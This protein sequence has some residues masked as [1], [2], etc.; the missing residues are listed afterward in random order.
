[1]EFPIRINKYLAEKGHATRR[2]A[3]ALIDSGIVFVNGKN[4][5]IGQQIQASDKVEVRGVQTNSHQYLLY[6]KPRGVITHS[7]APHETDIAMQIK[8][9]HSVEGVFP[10]GRLD[11]DSEG[12]ILLTNDGRITK[13][14][15]DPEN[16]HEKEYEV[17]VDKRVTGAFLRQLAHGVSI[18]GYRTKS[19]VAV[20]DTRNEHKFNIT[21]TEGKKHQIRRMCA[22]LGYQ[23]VE[24]KRTRIIGFS[25]RPLT[26]G[27]VR[28][29]SPR[30]IQILY[31]TL[32]ILS[33]QRN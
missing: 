14:L 12:L 28:K 29:L 20:V 16:D 18:E 4:A 17:L 3:D 23:V 32:G 27:K 26:V 13:R 31:K 25:I 10:V 15:L 7:P 21:L 24:L 1:V 2:G 9:D 19:A 11:K 33:P 8:A 5:L 6:Y 30:E 22:A